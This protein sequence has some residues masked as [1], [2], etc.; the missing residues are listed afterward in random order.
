MDRQ[1]YLNDKN[2]P[3]QLTF[4]QTGLDKKVLGLQY[5]TYHCYTRHKILVLVVLIIEDYD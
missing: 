3:L 4:K 5:S 1:T 2:F